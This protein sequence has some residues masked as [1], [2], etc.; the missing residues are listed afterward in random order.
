MTKRYVALLTTALIIGMGSVFAYQWWAESR[1]EDPFVL[2]PNDPAIV[3]LGQKI[4]QEN[5]ASC[6][7]ANLEGEPNWRSRKPSGRLPAPPHDET[8]HTW[9]HA[10]RVLVDLTKYGP[11][12][13]AGA[14]YQ[15]DMPAFEG[16]ISDEEIIAAL[17]YIKSTWNKRERE[18]QDE[19]TRRTVIQ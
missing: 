1:V 18:T 2:R 12:F 9:H 10:D 4:Y 8:G 16:V 14:D 19:I 13:V 11:Q 17:S 7:G 6:H 3:S 5:C 15:S